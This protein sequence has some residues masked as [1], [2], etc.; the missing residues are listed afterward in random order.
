[1]NC[2]VLFIAQIAF[3]NIMDFSLTQYCTL[4]LTD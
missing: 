4:P 2:I 3:Y 1:M